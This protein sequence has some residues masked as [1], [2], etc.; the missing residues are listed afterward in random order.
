VS[1]FGIICIPET[2]PLILLLAINTSSE[3]VNIMESCSHYSK[4]WRNVLSVAWLYIIMAVGNFFSAHIM[5]ADRRS[6]GVAPLILNLGT[7]WRWMVK[8][9]PSSTLPLRKNRATR[10]VGSWVVAVLTSPVSITWQ[11]A[12]MFMHYSTA[13]VISSFFIRN[14]IQMLD[15]LPLVVLYCVT[16]SVLSSFFILN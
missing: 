1:F 15:V 12:T 4:F 11:P 8:F 10:S 16:C 7:R 3:Y 14:A 2:V 6:R 5:K 13:S 9:I